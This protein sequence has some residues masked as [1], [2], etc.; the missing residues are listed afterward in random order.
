[1]K[2]FKLISLMFLS[3]LLIGYNS[4]FANAAQNK[5]INADI[6]TK[7]IPSGTV[8]KLKLIDPIGTDNMSLGDQFDLMTLE[9]IRVDKSIIIPA[10][11]VVR[12][13]IQKINP[14][15]MLS[16]GAIMY[17]DFDHIVAPTGK[18]VPLK[19]GICVSPNLTYDGGLGSKT[20]YGTATVVNAK[21]TAKIVKVSTNWGWKT[22]E[23]LLNGYPKYVLAPISAAFSA[24][25]AGMYFLGDSI[26]D[27]F[28]KGDDIQL[29][30]GDTLNVMLL[31]PLDMPMY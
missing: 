21:N 27:I 5:T 29:N 20:N 28:K 17:L 15:R 11:S 3:L 23:Q 19:V 22:G 24:P 6:G 8:V 31:K 26:V 14:K 4:T 2:K 13:S 10:G 12:G 30:Q 18:Q 1:M 7:R 25:V 9:D 16:K